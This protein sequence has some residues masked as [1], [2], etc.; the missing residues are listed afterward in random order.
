VTLGNTGYDDPLGAPT[1]GSRVQIG[2]G[3]KILGRVTIGNDVIIGANAVVID[4]VPSNAV[5][6]GIPARP[7][8]TEAQRDM[9]A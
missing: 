1:I 9:Q 8:K 7:L 5:V 6:G 3:A 2:A 4:D